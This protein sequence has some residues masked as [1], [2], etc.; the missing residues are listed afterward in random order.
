MAKIS[1]IFWDVGGVL[2][3]NAWD[4]NERREAVAHFGLDADDFEQRHR[5][6]V[7]DFETGRLGLEQYLNHTIFYRERQFDREAFRQFMF[8][9]SK[10]KPDA[11]TVA[12][13]LAS[14]SSYLMSTINNESAELNEYRIREFQLDE[15]FDLFVSSCFVGLRKPSPEI[16]QLAMNLTQ[17]NPKECCFIDDRPENLQPASLLGMH[18]IRMEGADKLR[19]ELM[20]LGVEF[21]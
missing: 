15:V 17:R 16:Y 10:S 20:A 6:A 8:S 13:K 2:L 5:S 19:N 12:R 1:A 4:H 21:R 14:S 9:R 3:S 11:L 18:T 7:A